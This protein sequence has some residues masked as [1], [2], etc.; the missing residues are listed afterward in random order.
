LL[1]S[2]VLRHVAELF[3]LRIVWLLGR[4]ERVVADTSWSVENFATAIEVAK[5]EGRTP[6][7]TLVRPL[8][9]GSAATA[10]DWLRP[11]V[12]V[13][14]REH[15]TGRGTAFV[16]LQVWA[17]DRCS[18]AEP[19]A[20][21]I[22]DLIGICRRLAVPVAGIDL[23]RQIMHELALGTRLPVQTL[24]CLL[25]RRWD[26]SAPLSHRSPSPPPTATTTVET[27]ESSGSDPA[28]TIDL[29]GMLARQQ[30]THDDKS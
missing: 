22:T 15:V 26:P 6:S 27:S 21:Q 13:V 10:D 25:P 24:G 5:Q 18:T 23:P 8:C 4:D 12:A 16:T 1:S 30:C 2:E 17:L 9:D 11:V 3:H 29:Y 28:T 19:Q 14:R 7:V 20:Q